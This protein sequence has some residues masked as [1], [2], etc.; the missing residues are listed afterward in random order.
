M[1]IEQQYNNVNKL[2]CDKIILYVDAE[3][4]MYIYY[5]E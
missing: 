2:T 1:G 3:I 4:I 5:F